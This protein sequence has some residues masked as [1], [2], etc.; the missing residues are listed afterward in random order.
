MTK[1]FSAPLSRFSLILSLTAGAA[2]CPAQSTSPQTA[3][4][5][6]AAPAAPAQPPVD[7]NAPE[8]ATKEAPALFKTRVNL[9]MVP[10]V[11]RDAKGHTVGTYTKENFLLF[12]KGKPQE[13]I[14]FSME[15]AGSKAAKE[16][17]TQDPIP[18]TEAAPTP[19][20]PERFV[21][22]LFDDMHLQ[23]GDLVR[24]RDAA[25]RQ[26]G[27]LAKTDRA[28]I[29]TTS[30][31]DQLEFTDDIDKL[32]ED[33]LRLR[34]RS[35][36]DPN[37]IASCP[38]ISYYMADMI[39]NK[40]D[41]MA[42]NLAVQEVIA[43]NP[44]TTA[45]TGAAFAQAA[46]MRVL[47][48]GTQETH[49]SLGVLKDVV[50][51]MSGMP[52]ERIVV[53]IS[54][55]FIVPQDQQEKGDILDRAIH[56]NVLINSMD[57]RGLW[58]DPMLDASRPTRAA[59]PAFLQLKQQYDRDSASAQADLLAEMAYGT[60]GS[61]YQNNN[62]LDTGLRQLASPPE[63][64]YILGFSPQNLKLDGSFHSLKVTFKPPATAGLAIQSRKGYYAPKKLTDAQ[65]TAK[66]EIEEA[67]F[68]REEMNELPVELH[69]QYFKA[70]EKDA[71]IA[72]LCRMDPKHIQ[73]HKADGRN[74]NS[75]TIVAGIF[76]RNGNFLS[77]I[78]KV[79]DLKLK[80]ETL[81]KLVAA[82][83]FSVK[84]NFSVAPGTYM[85]RLVVRDSEGQLMSAANGAVAI[86]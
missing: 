39:I 48:I 31:Q 82:G 74:I 77:G 44:G 37:G 28:A 71:T 43:C 33:L 45:A 21:A 4:P 6:A 56:S 58:V 50:R 30:G 47:S 69:T 79:V 12:D 5:P 16:A 64:Y 9:V 76:D 86:Q 26:M 62:D 59:T 7:K 49:V 19:D 27:A 24:A 1:H 17:Q 67:L 52:G 81:A 13:I 10:V 66:Q 75:L 23:F 55:G 85:V 72:V 63:F 25:G 36:S 41:S 35:I 61:F 57:A 29:Y 68:S 18:T 65:E 73:F 34:P 14:K 32:Q 54:P 53:M 22:Y 78:Q 40:N 83:V 2:L 8:M 80:D 15:K 42:L 51:R 84:T 3:P 60:G 70:S 11:V 38:D 20:V 46:S